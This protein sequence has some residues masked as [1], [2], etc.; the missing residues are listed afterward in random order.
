MVCIPSWPRCSGY[1]EV[2]HFADE[3]VDTSLRIFYIQLLVYGILLA[4]L[5][6]VVEETR[7]PVIRARLT[8]VDP[9][10]ARPLSPLP[11]ANEASSE[12]RKQETS[13]RPAFLPPGSLP[14][15]FLLY[16][17]TIRPFHMLFT[18]PVVASFSLWSGFCFGI[19]YTCIQSI[20]QIY[21]ANYSFTDSQ[22]G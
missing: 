3:S 17:A 22:C 21:Q 4:L 8:M 15:R 9:S 6:L 1:L 12:K 2:P 18:E 11:S 19:V 5:L 14:L 7:G 16:K 13:T 20:S 10:L